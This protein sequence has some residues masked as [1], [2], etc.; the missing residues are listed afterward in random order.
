[1]SSITR[2]IVLCC[3]VG[4]AVSCGGGLLDQMAR[5]ASDPFPQS[6]RVVSFVTENKIDV[7]WD[8]DKA[9][10]QYVLERAD[11]S[12]NPAFA[13]VY[14]GTGTSYSDTDCTDQ[15]RYLYRLSKT[16]GGKTLGPSDFVMGVCSA[17]CR[18]A[19][20][21]NDAEMQASVLTSTLAANLYY[22]TSF[23]HQNGAPLVHQDADWYAVSVPPHRIANIVV[24]QD[25]LAQGSGNTWMNFY[26]KG[27][28][29][30][31]IPNGNPITI[32]NYSDVAAVTFLFK[33]YPEPTAFA[34][35][36]GGSLISYTVSLDSITSH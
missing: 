21:P 14:Q 22:Y 30:V 17:V 4:A 3:A 15:C 27:V 34:A 6:P 20:E 9:A 28:N 1:M 13:V 16:R 33:I 23:V 12:L 35:N 5:V 31:H 10:E 18:D 24:T 7:S 25:Q 2:V 36:G 11:D 19:L 26:Q 8:L 29:S 32:T